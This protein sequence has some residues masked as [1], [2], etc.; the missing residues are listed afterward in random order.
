MVTFGVTL[1]PLPPSRRMVELAQLAEQEG[2]DS[3]WLMDSPVLWQEMYPILGAM[4]LATTRVHLGPCVTNPTTRDPVVT[5]SAMATLHE[6]SGG[7]AEI[8]LG[9]G[10]SAR[11]AMGKKPTTAARLEEAVHM[12]RALTSGRKIERDDVSFSLPWAE[13]RVPIWLSGYGPKALELAGRVADGVIVQPADPEL[14][15]WFLSSVR[16]GAEAAGR[17]FDEISIMCTVPVYVTSDPERARDEARWFPAMVSNQIVEL[18]E[19]YGAEAMPES[20]GAFVEQR[21]GYSYDDH[22]RRDAA[23][24]AFVPD[25]VVDR[26][27]IIGDAQ[28]CLARVRALE[29]VG[30]DRINAYCIAEDPEG[31]LRAIGRELIG[32]AQTVEP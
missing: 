22:G 2:F 5:A 23:H 10:D 17:D 9:R 28:E 11:R 24:N 12:I 27:C 26:F 4:A 15:E 6:L 32:P 21:K 8:G 18:V 29:E 30:V 13:G 1:L 14:L 19:R 16:R 31:L 3:V 20:F 25:E 7:R